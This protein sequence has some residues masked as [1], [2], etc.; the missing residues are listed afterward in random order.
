MSEVDTLSFDE[1]KEQADVLGVKYAGNIG[2]S[3]LR[4]KLKVTLGE[5]PATEAAAEAPAT[6]AAP[7]TNEAAAAETAPEATAAPKRVKIVIDENETDQQPVFVGLNGRSYVIKRGEEVSVPPGVVDILT[8]ATMKKYNSKTMEAR[9]VPR[10][11]FRVV[12]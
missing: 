5:I 7:A 9:M 2:E 6:P 12:G 10:Y 11:P 3:T 1:L 4:E 8:N